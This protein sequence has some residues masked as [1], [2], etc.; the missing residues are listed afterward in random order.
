L[1]RLSGEPDISEENEMEIGD[2]AGFYSMTRHKHETPEVSS[3]TARVSETWQKRQGWDQISKPYV[4]ALHANGL[5]IGEL[6]E[7]K[8]SDSGL[9]NR[10]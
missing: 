6:L 2:K 5:P 10:D 1:S 3:E 8:S 9:E 4:P 7:W